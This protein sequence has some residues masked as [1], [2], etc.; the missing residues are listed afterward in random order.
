MLL[1]AGDAGVFWR[2]T[3]LQAFEHD[4]GSVTDTADPSLSKALQDLLQRIKDE[5]E[6]LDSLWD[7]Q[8]SGKAAAHWWQDGDLDQEQADR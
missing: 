6:R 5:T 4:I 3:R 8:R 1:C 7:Q 2:A